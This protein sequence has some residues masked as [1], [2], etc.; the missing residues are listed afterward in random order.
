MK[1]ADPKNPM[2]YCDNLMVGFRFI[3]Q[4]AHKPGHD[5]DRSHE[6]RAYSL[7]AD[8]IH[9]DPDKPLDIPQVTIYTELPPQLV[10]IRKGRTMNEACCAPGMAMRWCS[11]GFAIK[12]IVAQFS[13]LSHGEQRIAVARMANMVGW[14]IPP[15]IQDG[16]S[17]PDPPTGF[18]NPPGEP[19]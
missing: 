6:I 19:E 13:M 10:P 7:G 2:E 8:P 17:P 4:A 14:K 11:N 16:E 15:W 1:I 9:L 18:F 3:E 5:E 12:G